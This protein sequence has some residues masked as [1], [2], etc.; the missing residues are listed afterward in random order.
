MR[1]ARVLLTALVFMS[2]GL[3][4]GAQEPAAR[5]TGFHGFLFGDVVYVARERAATDGFF[6]GQL[7]GH[8]N[9][10]MSERA[11]FFGEVSATARPDGYA[12]EVERAILRYDFADAL[13]VSAGRYHTPVSYWNTAYHHGLWLQTSV[14]RPEIIKVGGRFMPVHFIGLLAEGTLSAGRLALTY[15]AGVGNGRGSNFARG[16]DAGDVNRSRAALLA[17]RL[18]PFDAG[19]Q[20]GGSVYFDRVVT[21]TLLSTAFDERITSAHLVWDRGAPEFAAEYARVRHDPAL[22]G[23]AL[24]SEG[25]YAQGAY[26]LGG[27]FYRFK[28]YARIERLDAHAADP[29]FTPEMDYR[30]TIAGLRYD[31]DSFAALKGEYRRERFGGRA[32]WT[33]GWYLQVAFAVATSGGL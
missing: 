16:G 29:V 3:E 8:G 11:S 22:G 7:V 25:W 19:L 32:D 4:I 6:V 5:T 23:Q 10:R 1:I 21:D 9:A 30:A 31:F 26:R 24:S 17:A 13:K 12:F 20:I 18:R 27:V 14:A 28:P 2:V 33:N 15:E